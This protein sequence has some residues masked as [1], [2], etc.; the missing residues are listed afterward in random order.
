MKVDDII[1]NGRRGCPF[2]SL[3][4]DVLNLFV[5]NW[6]LRRDKLSLHVIAPNRRP[7]EVMVNEADKPDE[8]MRGIISISLSN[9]K[10]MSVA[11]ECHN[12]HIFFFR[13]YYPWTCESWN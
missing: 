13:N 9:P 2:C 8:A 10:G 5:P 7:F 3:F 12:T 11:Y 1:D 4:L 6:Q